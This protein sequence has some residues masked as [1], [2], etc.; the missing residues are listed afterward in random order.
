LQSAPHAF[1]LV[2]LGAGGQPEGSGRPF[3]QRMVPLPHLFEQSGS[4]ARSST[5]PLQSL[6]CPSHISAVRALVALQPPS[7]GTNPGPQAP[8][9]S[10][11]FATHCWPHRRNPPSHLKSQDPP[12][13]VAVAWSGLG[14][15]EQESPHEAVLLLSL[16]ALS[17]LW[18]PLLQSNPQVVP[19]QVA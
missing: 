10:A 9:H 19:A 1:L 8:L 7:Q 17:H 5:V 16:H 4:F 3:T 18:K 6:S 11:S 13:Q 14:Q 15:G 12:L 2:S